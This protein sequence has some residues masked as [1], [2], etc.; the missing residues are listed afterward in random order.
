MQ[1]FLIQLIAFTVIGAV[2]YGLS[3]LLRCRFISY[4]FDA[5]RS[6][7]RALVA[8][9]VGMMIVLPL[10]LRQHILHGPTP[11]LIPKLDTV[12]HILFQLIIMAIVYVAPAAYCMFK[13]REELATAGIGGHNLW[14]ACVIGLTLGALACCNRPTDLPAKLSNL[15]LSQWLLLVH[16]SMVG[17]GEEFLFRGYLQT[18]LIAWL[19][20][21]RG[22]VFAS[23]VM[24]A[25]HFPHRWLI[26]GMSPGEAVLATAGLMPVSLLMGF[27]MLRT[28]NIVAPAIFHTFADWAGNVL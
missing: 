11:G 18:R 20:P 7:L 26:G 17:F 10:M 1:Q 23:V 8:V 19:G 16:Y 14:Q 22:W 13:G 25:V 3:K 4:S 6:S 24:A 21:W 5:R 15:A 27:I 9:A 2:V 12:S 28:Q